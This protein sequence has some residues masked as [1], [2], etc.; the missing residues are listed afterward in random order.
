MLWLAECFGVNKN[1]SRFHHT[2][3]RLKTN[4]FFSVTDKP[5]VKAEVVLKTARPGDLIEF[6]RSHYKHWAML[7]DIPGEVFNVPA[8]SKNDK[9]VTI[10]QEKLTHV[11]RG[12]RVRVNNQ[13]RMAWKLGCKPRPKLEALAAAKSDVGKTFEYNFL[14][15]NCE[16]YCTNWFYGEGF[17]AQ[18]GTNS[19]KIKFCVT[20]IKN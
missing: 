15:T 10:S 12:D 17:T 7:S 9:K 13:E 3:T 19:K 2:L 1:N 16:H 18:V 11:A 8:E 14:S 5:F 6:D 20:T 4:Y